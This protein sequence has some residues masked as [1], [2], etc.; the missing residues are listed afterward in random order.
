MNEELAL[1]ALGHVHISDA[2]T[3]EVLLN[4]FNALHLENL[5]EGLANSLANRGYGH[6]HEMVFGNGAS[7]ISGTGAVTYFPPN[8]VGADAQLYHQTYRKVVDDGSPQ[9]TDPT[10]NYL[11]VNHVQ[12]MSYT[13]ISIQCRLERGEP[14]GQEA[15]D[16]AT[17]MEGNFVFD[18][19][20]FKSYSDDP[21]LARLLGHIVFNPIQKSLNRALKFKYTVRLYML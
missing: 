7:T 10:K 4:A 19:L 14:A 17:D 12:N 18:E 3:G 6:I 20:G 21:D 9:N 16:D 15:F 2:D 1:R 8:A 11:T 13:D 5:S